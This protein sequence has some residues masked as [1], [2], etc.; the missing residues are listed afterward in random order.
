[1]GALLSVS[2]VLGLIGSAFLCCQ[3][4]I[5]V[6]CSGRECPLSLSSQ[7][8]RSELISFILFVAL[9]DC[10]FGASVFTLSGFLLGLVACVI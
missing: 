10:V 9:L 2:D 5:E 1:M 7:P 8:Q 6:L 4:F 3:F